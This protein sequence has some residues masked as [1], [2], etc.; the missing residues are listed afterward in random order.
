MLVKEDIVVAVF[1]RY[2]CTVM[3]VLC[4]QQMVNAWSTCCAVSKPFAPL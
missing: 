4:L 1:H 2:D 3:L